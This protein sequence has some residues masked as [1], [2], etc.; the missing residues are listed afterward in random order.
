MY[1]KTVRGRVAFVSSLVCVLSAVAT[2]GFESMGD[3]YWLNLAHE[4]TGWVYAL[5]FPVVAVSGLLLL[6]GDPIPK[7]SLKG[8]LAGLHSLVLGTLSLGTGLCIFV[9]VAYGGV[10]AYDHYTTEWNCVEKGQTMYSISD[11]GEIG[12]AEEACTCTGMADFERRNW[13]RVDYAGLNKDHGCDF[14]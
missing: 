1:I 8:F 5:S 4:V 14:D 11:K 2:A 7:W 9:A 13:G 3:S 10:L 6:L 12:P